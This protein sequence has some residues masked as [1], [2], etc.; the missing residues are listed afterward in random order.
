MTSILIHKGSSIKRGHYYSCIKT[1][2]ENW[3]LFNDHKV[4]KINETEVFKQEAYLLFYQKVF[5]KENGIFF[6]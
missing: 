5:N 3:Y 4:K 2:D 6:I 1:F